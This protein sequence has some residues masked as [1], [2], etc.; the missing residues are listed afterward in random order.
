MK[1]F[2]IFLLFSN[3]LICESLTNKK[4]HSP[5][6][7]YWIKI[8]KENPDFQSKGFIFPVGKG[9]A[10]GYYIAQNF[11]QKNKH[12]GDN[13]HLGEDWNG[14]GGG[15]TDYGDPILAISNGLVVY[16]G[17]GGPGWGDVIRVIHYLGNKNSNPIFMESIYGHVSKTFVNEGDLISKGK[18]IAEIGDAGGIYYAHLHLELRTDP[19]MELGGGYA[20]ETRGFI[21]PKKYIKK[22]FNLK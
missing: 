14:N 4:Q 6:K 5:E 9:K 3:F 17:F 19:E 11:R 8:F 20:K 1:I 12:F 18:K 15:N 10:K 2:L 7:Q 16:T 13:Y 21:E 22:H